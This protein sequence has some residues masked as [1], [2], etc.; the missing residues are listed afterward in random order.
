[1]GTVVLVVAA[2][3]GLA[4]VPGIPG[5][6]QAALA[7]QLAVADG[8]T[9]VTDVAPFLGTGRAG[10]CA[11]LESSFEMAT[12][13]FK[14]DRIGWFASVWP[15]FQALDALYLG[16]LLPGGENCNRDFQQNLA[17]IDRTYWDHSVPGFPPDY[18]QGPSVIHSSSDF[19]RVDDNLWMGLTL[20]RA[21]E[22]SH[23]A[24]LLQRA[25]DVFALAQHDWNSQ[26][27][28]VYWEVHARGASDEERAVVSNAP[29]VILGVQLFRLTHDTTYLRWSERIFSWLQ[30]T[31]FDRSTG[32]YDDHIQAVAGRVTLDTSK[33]TYNQGVMIGAMVALASVDPARY[34][35]APAVTLAKRSMAY[36]GAHRD[37][38]QPS[39]DVVWA[40]NVLI[41]AERYG[42][43]SFATNARNSVELAIRAAPSGAGDLT[44]AT[45]ELALRELLRVPTRTYGRFFF[46]P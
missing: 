43:R 12:G 15:S 37:Y 4:S 38:G 39:L 36:F 44:D 2:L 29:A 8:K 20:T 3:C 22:R 30:R 18:D 33:F 28:G 17:A 11:N 1:M 25:K 14:S 10:T 32:L 45:S 34:T 42:H 13:T 9:A 35:L 7:A 31:L 41:L 6:P 21:Y 24:M 16:S 19:P 5:H 40:E 26:S 46:A 27:G 23:T